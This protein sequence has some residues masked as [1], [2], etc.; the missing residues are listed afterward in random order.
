MPRPEFD[1][2]NEERLD[3]P[4]GSGIVE[5][6]IVLLIIGIVVAAWGPSW[7]DLDHYGDILETIIRAMSADP[8]S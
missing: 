7:E 6:L 4:K 2:L 3:T 5:I 1:G 8:E